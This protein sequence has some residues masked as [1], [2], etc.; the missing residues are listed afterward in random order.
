M[1]QGSSF[2]MNKNCMTNHKNSKKV[3][4]LDGNLYI[5]KSSKKSRL[6]AFLEPSIAVPG[7]DQDMVDSWS[8][9]LK[10]L[11]QWSSTFWLVKA[12]L[13]TKGVATEQTL[14]EGN[15]F[16]TQ[17]KEYKTPKKE[18]YK[19]MIDTSLPELYS[20]FVPEAG[21]FSSKEDAHNFMVH[22]ESTFKMVNREIFK[23]NKNQA[24][25]QDL[26]DNSLRNLDL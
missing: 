6:T 1:G 8:R 24:V 5:V 7:L 3:T 10:T 9:S 22:I 25:M 11:K 2:C 16:A 17:L 18:K 23:L 14:S 12:A 15:E 20:L 26:M 21:S 19:Q 4:I 13:E